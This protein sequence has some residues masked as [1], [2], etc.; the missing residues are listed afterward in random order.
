LADAIDKPRGGLENTLGEREGMRIEAKEGTRRWADK[1]RAGESSNGT[2]A[3][4]V[5]IKGE[6]VDGFRRRIGIG[7]GD[8]V[9]RRR[10][11]K[12]WMA[13]ETVVDGGWQ[14]GDRGW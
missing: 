2:S 5:E 7:D 14:F 1:G 4:V 10:R 3:A 8:G 11:R 12:S 6:K 9:R 13:Q